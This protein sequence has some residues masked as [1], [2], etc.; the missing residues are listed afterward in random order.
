MRELWKC[1]MRNLLAIAAFFGVSM[2]FLQPTPVLFAQT[3]V[4]GGLNGVVVDSTGAVVSGA[5]VTLVATN[6][7]DTRVLT[8]N[9][10]GLYTAPFLKPGVYAVSSSARGLQSTTTSVEILVGQQSV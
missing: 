4:T 2:S 3:A 1:R 10:R 7:G 5:T 6:T 9:D 8:T